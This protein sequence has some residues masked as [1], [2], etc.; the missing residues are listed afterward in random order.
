MAG[1]DAGYYMRSIMPN[2]TSAAKRSRNVM[3]QQSAPT[4]SVDRHSVASIQM[5]RGPMVRYHTILTKDL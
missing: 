3:S 5:C 1:R 2:R 4:E